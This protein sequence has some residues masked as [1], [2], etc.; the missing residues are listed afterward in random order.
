MTVKQV[1]D[2]ADSVKPNAFTSEEKLH[3]LGEL[4]G[5]IGAELMFMSVQDL[6]ELELRYPQDMTSELLVSP[7]YDDVYYYWLLTR[8]D[9]SNGEFNKA[10]NTQELFRARYNSFANWFLSRYD[11]VQG[12]ISR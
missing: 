5:R 12:Y 2:R 11:P 8:I 1:I 9:E 6:S 7:P 10:A 4:E 3:W